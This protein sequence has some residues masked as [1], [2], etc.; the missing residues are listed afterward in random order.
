MQENSACECRCGCCDEHEEKEKEKIRSHGCDCGCDDDDD[1]DDEGSLAWRITRLAVGGAALAFGIAASHFGFIGKVPL[2]IIYAAAYLLLG[3]DVL[4]KAGKSIL[5]G[6]VFN[7]NFLMSIS[8]LG[9]FAIGEYAEAVAVMLFFGLGEFLEDLA[10]DRSRDSITELMDIRP[11][12]AAVRRDGEW[13]DVSPEEIEIGDEI[14]IKPGEKVPLD[15]TVVDGSSSLDT[16]ALTGE[17]VPRSIREGEECMSGC[18]NLTSPLILRVTKEFGESTA[19]RL[20]ALVE[21]AQSVKSRGESVI[22]RFARI[23]TPIV[24]ALAAAVAVIPSIIT[25]DWATWIHRG[26][27]T[28]VI[29]CPCAL[30]VSV[31][32]TYF[33]GL[34][35]ASR[36]GLLVKGSTYLE[37]LADVGTVALDKTGTLTKGV[38]AV[39]HVHPIGVSESELLSDAAAVERFSNHPIARSIVSACGDSGEQDI[40]DYREVAGRGVTADVRGQTII[41][42]NAA[43]FAENGIATAEVGEVGTIVHVAKYG[44]YEGYIVISD[45]IKPESRAAVSEMRENGVAVVMLTG[46]SETVAAAVSDELGISDHR[47]ALLPDGKVSAIESMLGSGKKKLTFV[48]DGINDAPSLARADIGI[49]MG[50]VGSDAAIEAAD[51]VLM[52]DDLGAINRSIRISKKVR[53][54]IRENIT[55]ALAVKAILIVLGW[56]G[57]A[58]MWTAVFGDVG[59]LL[60]VIANSMRI[61]K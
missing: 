21:H 30:V 31:P 25:G 60:I 54:I 9:A 14:L 32:L 28:L 53:A 3:Y 2:I 47:S 5:R 58:S 17:S 13:V 8:T 40:S 41:A 26:L 24:V 34:G 38:F 23:Y 52:T 10:V 44:N 12:R 22:S 7:E 29:S 42:G 19:A 48:G 59:V 20:L 56:F 50:G 49:A 36:S 35:A 61:I 4:F 37:S 57:I 16:R 27:V 1:D 15:G 39:T 43:F 33:G 6:K 11:D 46:D 45:E 51:A 18:V 55:F